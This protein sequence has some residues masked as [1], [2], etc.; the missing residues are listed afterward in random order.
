[1]KIFQQFNA[2]KLPKILNKLN[3]AA[4]NETEST[5]FNVKIN[6]K[7]RP[8]YKWYQD[9]MELKLTDDYELI[10]KE[11][12]ITL[13]IKSCKAD[14]TGTYYL[15]FKNSF[16]EAASNKAKLIVNSKLSFK[17]LSLTRLIF[18]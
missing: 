14:N 5:S 12:E 3:N 4:V 17:L 7:D 10:E 9:E 13:V 8:P 18:K 6:G 11:D 15:K 1:M 16:G 2:K